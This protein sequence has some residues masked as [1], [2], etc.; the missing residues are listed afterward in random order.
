M[1]GRNVSLSFDFRN[2]TDLALV[3]IPASQVSFTVQP[4]NGHYAHYYSSSTY[5]RQ[6]LLERLFTL[7]AAV[8]LLMYLASLILGGKRIAAEQIMVLQLCYL[9]FLT[10]PAFTP[11]QYSV[12]A[13]RIATNGVNILYDPALPPFND[14][15]SDSTAKGA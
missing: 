6:Q 14:V 9:S 3:E 10:L 11:L 13:L 15:L 12:T 8:A 2:A 5:Q 1:Q 7:L 4:G